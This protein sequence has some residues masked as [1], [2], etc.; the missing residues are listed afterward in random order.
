MSVCYCGVIA[1]ISLINIDQISYKNSLDELMIL[2]STSF[3]NHSVDVQNFLREINALERIDFDLLN[4]NIHASLLELNK[5]LGFDEK[6][7]N[8]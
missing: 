8:H 4:I 1:K 3:P 2:V 7:I 5:I 6:N